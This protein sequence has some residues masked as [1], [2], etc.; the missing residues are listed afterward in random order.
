MITKKVSVKVLNKTADTAFVKSYDEA[1]DIYIFDLA[2]S[3]T[4]DEGEVSYETLAQHRYAKKSEAPFE[5]TEEEFNELT[6][7]VV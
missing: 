1:N 5:L 3:S 7:A 6:C 4:N 2:V